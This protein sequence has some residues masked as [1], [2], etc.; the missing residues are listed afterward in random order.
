MI[1]ILILLFILS[2]IPI[3]A[4]LDPGS[5]AVLINLIIAGIAALLYSLKNIIFKLFSKDKNPKKN[6]ES[7]KVGILS[8]GKQYWATFQPIINAFIKYKIPFSYYTLDIEDPALTIDNDLMESQFLGYKKWGFARASLLKIENL[9]CT[10]PNIGC[11]E[12][13]IRKSPNIKNLIHIFHSINDLAMYK[14]GSLDY[15]DIVLMVGPFQEK[16]IR[17][18][19]QKRNLKPKKL[20]NV[21]LPYLD[22]YSSDNDIIIKSD[23]ALK[24]IL[25]GSSWGD[26]GLLKVYG[27]EFITKLAAYG[28]EIIIRPHPQSFISELDLIKKLKGETKNFNNIHWDDSISPVE[29][30]KKA[31]ILISDTSSLRF[32]FAFI[33]NKPV[34]TLKIET[35]EMPG[36]ERDELDSIWMEYA[37]KEIGPILTKESLDMIKD[38][39]EKA[40]TEFN[41]HRILKFRNET[42]VNYGKAGEAIAEYFIKYSIEGGNN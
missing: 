5:G 35:E 13:P 26:K 16:S 2:P 40:L 39:I 1:I 9:I 29:S 19:E 10:T 41:A 8:E 33:Y 38:Y 14:K 22:V 11:A 3:Y 30:M 12:Y 27:T 25:I 17:E 36:Y 7:N 18:L 4:Y 28:Y 32:D 34:I 37:E 20:I 21:G 23:T 42:I 31:D 24:T 6:K 15:Y